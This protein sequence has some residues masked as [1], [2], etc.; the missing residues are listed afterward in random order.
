VINAQADVE[1][2][3]LMKEAAGFLDSK[4]A[5]QIRYLETITILGKQTSTKVIFLPEE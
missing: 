1:S 5:M 2:A 4:A 3:K